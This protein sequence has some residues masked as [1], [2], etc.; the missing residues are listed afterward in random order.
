MHAESPILAGSVEAADGGIVYVYGRGVLGR[1]PETGE[2][3]VLAGHHVVVELV[4]RLHRVA[5]VG[6]A[7]NEAI[8]LAVLLLTADLQEER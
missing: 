2:L 5:A 6:L 3:I 4:D 7:L 8:A 1:E